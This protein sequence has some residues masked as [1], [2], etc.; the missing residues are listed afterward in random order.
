LLAARKG[1]DWI[2]VGSVGTGFNERSAEHL[3]K[4]LDRIKRKTPPVKYAGR[5][6]SL[7]WV[8]PTLIVEIAYR[9]WTHDGKLRHASY[10]DLRE[11]KDNAA[12]YEISDEL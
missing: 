2:Y 12:V 9:A 5:R 3:R 4:I 8:Q 7:V 6:K 10:K 11:L 1:N